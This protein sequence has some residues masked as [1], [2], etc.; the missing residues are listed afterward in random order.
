[1]SELV[2]I[3]RQ[4][5][6]DVLASRV[7]G[8][9]LKPTPEKPLIISASELRDFLRCRVKHHWRHQCRLEPVDGSEN[10][11]IGALVH[12]ILEAWYKLPFRERSPKRIEKLASERLR[13]TTFKELTTEHK[14]LIGAMCIGYAFW[15]KKEDR[16]IG[17]E[18]CSPE[19][20]FEEPLD[21][22]R[23]I[24]VR[25]KIDNVFTPR[26]FKHTIGCQETKTKGQI[27]VD[28]VETNLQLS[29]YLWALRRLFPKKKRYMAYY[30]ILRKQMPGPRVKSDLFHREPVERMDEEIEQWEI[31]TRR[32]ALDMLDGA[33]YPNPMDSCSWDCDYRMPCLFRGR[34]EDLTHVLTTQ[35]KP[36]EKR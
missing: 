26:A 4:T 21:A 28:M 36:K 24:L 14:E 33:I 2:S 16:E 12:E 25:G 27:R 31:D 17:L 7:R 9:G 13:R 20:W 30:T 15:A 35:Y 29:V 10:L 11:A 8:G 5:A 6:P 23:T 18:D 3:H 19:M 22:K 1:M 34:P 32:A